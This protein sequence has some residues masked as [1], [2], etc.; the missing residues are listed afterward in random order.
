MHFIWADTSDFH[1]ECEST[2]VK[3]TSACRVGGRCSRQ[4]LPGLSIAM[5]LRRQGGTP[6]VPPLRTLSPA[7]T[8]LRLLYVKMKRLIAHAVDERA[9]GGVTRLRIN[10]SFQSS[11]TTV[12]SSLHLRAGTAVHSEVQPADRDCKFLTEGRGPGAPVTLT[13]NFCRR[14][15]RH[16][17]R[18]LYR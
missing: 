12:A 10:R 6:P 17:L 8:S 18:I 11:P 5:H 9:N 3:S 15:F 4:I 14:F 7:F 2:S 13:A 1:R 16:P